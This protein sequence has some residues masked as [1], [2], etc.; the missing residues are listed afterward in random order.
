M[1]SEQ[2]AKYAAIE[3]LVLAELHKEGLFIYQL[4]E[5]LVSPEVSAEDVAAAFWRLF[6]RHAVELD[7]HLLITPSKY[8]EAAT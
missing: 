7:E 8:E 5:R 1:T 3:K 4:Y 6:T 2:A